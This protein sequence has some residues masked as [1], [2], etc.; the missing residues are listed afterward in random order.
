[1]TGLRVRGLAVPP[2][3]MLARFADDPKVG[4]ARGPVSFELWPDAK[5]MRADLAAGAADLAVIPT[6][7]AAALYNA[8]VGVRLLAV[9]VWGI[10][11]VLTTR[12]F[13]D[14]P[15]LAAARIA[16]PL[17][18]NMP[19]TIFSVL[20]PKLGLDPESAA[21][22]YPAS[23]AAAKDALLA[24]EVDAAVLPEPVASAA[25]AEGTAAGA[26]VRRL[27]DLQTE[28]A[29]AMGGLARFPQAGAVATG[30]LTDADPE[31]VALLVSALRQANGWMGADPV[32]AGRLGATLLGGPSA[33]VITESLRTGTWDTLSALDARPELEAF[34][35]TLIE[36]A[37]GLVDGGLPDDEFY[38]GKG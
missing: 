8:N 13:G 30:P 36:R 12:D 25:L 34:Y 5:A 1:M 16:I 38:L 22:S 11:H 27:F 20:A 33:A 28:W 32:A 18:G 2:S 24:G 29:R 37:P 31:T 6:N 3:I 23:Y 9:T 35:R 4:E 21:L 14:W 19:D 15:G 26:P 17:K 7:V 10:L